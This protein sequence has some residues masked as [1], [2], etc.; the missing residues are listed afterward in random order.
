[1]RNSLVLAFIFASL[2][3]PSASAI[4]NPAL[5]EEA[6]KTAPE[7]LRIRIISAD[8]TRVSTDCPDGKSQ[9]IESTVK[10]RAL[11][12]EVLE[13][14]TGVRRGDVISIEYTRLSRICLGWTG[15][16]QVAGLGVG[17]QGFAY[18]SKEDGV[19]HPAAWDLSF[20]RI[21]EK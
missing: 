11:V 20:E 6:K 10:S 9:E 19:Y 8:V 13:T 21:K 12:L 15:P 1:M 3:V 14:K 17:K 2:L 18:L 4:I 7:K 16:Q 5:V